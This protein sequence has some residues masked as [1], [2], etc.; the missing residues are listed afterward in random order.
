M[1]VQVVDG[2]ACGVIG[3]VGLKRP[4]VHASPFTQSGVFFTAIW[5]DRQEWMQQSKNKWS[6]TKEAVCHG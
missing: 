5:D 3:G 6:E 2:Q 4:Y 1:L